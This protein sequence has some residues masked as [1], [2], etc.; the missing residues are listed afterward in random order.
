MLLCA[1]INHTSRLSGEGRQAHVQLGAQLAA[2]DQEA[3]LLELD[4]ESGPP[5]SSA[6]LFKVG[7]L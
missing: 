6:N 4:M 2:G 5:A 1:D 7:L 3:V